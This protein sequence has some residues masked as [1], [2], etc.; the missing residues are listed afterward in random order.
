ME[1]G[2]QFRRDEVMIYN[3]KIDRVIGINLRCQ[4]QG[5][6]EFTP[7]SQILIP[8]TL[9]GPEQKTMVYAVNCAIIVKFVLNFVHL[10]PDHD[11][12][13]GRG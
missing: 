13:R 2:V 10:Y 6:G 11:L 1:V 4:D 3:L 5:Q 8:Q 12:K 7:T 9:L